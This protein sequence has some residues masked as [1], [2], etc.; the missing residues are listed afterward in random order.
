VV[1]HEVIF[2]SGVSAPYTPSRGFVYWSF[3]WLFHIHGS[4]Q[5]NSTWIRSNKMHAGI[6]LL[7]ITLHFSGANHTH[8]Q[9]N[10]KL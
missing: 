2:V 5:R 6:Y 10:T 9:E 4:L 1:G 8:H 3:K 7:Q